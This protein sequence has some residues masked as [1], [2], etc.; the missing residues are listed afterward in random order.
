MLSGENGILQRAG[1]A[2][3]KTERAQFY[4]A[5][6]MAYNGLF[7]T[8]YLTRGEPTLDEVVTEMRKDGYTIAE[9]TISGTRVKGVTVNNSSIGVEKG[10]SEIVSYTVETE[11][12]EDVAV[13]LA[14]INGNK[15]EMNLN[16][17]EIT[18]E[19]EI[20]TGNAGSPGGNITVT[21]TTTDLN[22]VTATANEAENKI[23]INGL[24]EGAGITL[25][26]T[27]GGRTF[28]V[29]E[30]TVK[31]LTEAAPDI[32]VGGT[33]VTETLTL[34][35]AMLLS[36][37]Q[38]GS[39]TT[40]APVPSTIVNNKY[41]WISSNPEVVEVTSDGIIKCGSKTS[42]EAEEEKGGS[43]TVTIT[44]KGSSG[45]EKTCQVTSNAKKVTQTTTGGP[46]SILE[47]F[48]KINTNDAKWAGVTDAPE[49][50]KGLVI[51][52]ERG[53][54]F[55]WV[56]VPEVIAASRP[57]T[58]GVDLSTN[59][60]TSRPMAIARTD[61]V[62]GYEGLLY[63]F[64]GTTSTYESNYKLGTTSY[65]EPDVLRSGEDTNTSSDYGDFTLYTDR[66][67]N[68]LKKYITEYKEKDLEKE[69]DRASIKSGWTNQLNNEYKTMVTKVDSK[70]GF[71]V[72][73]YETSYD[74]R[75]DKVASIAGAR[76]RTA[77]A[78]ESTGM[79]TWYG[80]YQKQKDF[81]IGKSYTSSMIWGSQWDAMLN[82]MAKNGET[83]GTYDSNKRN[84]DSYFITGSIRNSLYAN[85]K[86]SNVIDIEGC[87]YEW[88]QEADLTGYRTFRRGQLL[89]YR[90]T[91]VP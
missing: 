39:G 7:T 58:T 2:K 54:Q 86:W 11:N 57:S 1:E 43:G 70:D 19:E 23:T 18:I 22:K 35:G 21:A 64:S 44:C 12:G 33:K 87:A 62:D 80:L 72:G 67:Y 34:D 38:V 53:N 25:K 41:L 51:M 52:D 10:G 47:G 16:D 17:G 32:Y 28:D 84:G 81:C 24:A 14:V 26:V 91:S 59:K 90:I 71:W 48:T 45:S 50:D 61:G 15:Y 83:I 69:E 73:R 3:D 82:W 55:V 29:G 66:G 78:A 56:P 85:D 60:N 88:T 37:G 31:E 4:E 6:V 76:S 30:I 13:Y 20:Y 75:L 77:D 5:A 27:A 8:K 46:S 63:T 36:A 40:S 89:R 42:S 49:V 79:R 9:D 65:R 74:E 68:L